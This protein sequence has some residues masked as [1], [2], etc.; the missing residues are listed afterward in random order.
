MDCKELLD[1]LEIIE[2]VKWYTKGKQFLKLLKHH[3]CYSLTRMN[4]GTS[5]NIKV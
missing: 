4:Y 5:Q 1:S 2:K 3:T